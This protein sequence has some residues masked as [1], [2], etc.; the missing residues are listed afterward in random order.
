MISCL[1]QMFL[2]YFRKLCFYFD[3]IVVVMF[4]NLKL[5][6]LLQVE[7]DFCCRF[8]WII[9]ED[10]LLKDLVIYEICGCF[11]EVKLMF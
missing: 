7:G 5:V 10:N 1:V 2:V 11:N 6:E 4:R 9:F 8:Y 3:I